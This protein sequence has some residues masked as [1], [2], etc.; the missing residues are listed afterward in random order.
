MIKI[1]KYR[2]KTNIILALAFAVLF[3][4]TAGCKPKDKIFTI[5][6]INDVSVLSPTFEGF[7]GGMAELDYIEGNNVRYIYNGVVENSQ[8][9]I[10]SEIK[11]LMAQD[12]D[13]FLTLGNNTSLLAKEALKETE[14]PILI[15]ACNKPIKYGLIESMSYAGGNIT[16]V[17]VADSGPKALEWLLMI[18]PGAKKIFL[19]YNPDSKISVISLEGLDKASS[20]LGIEIV[21][22]EVHSFEETIAAIENLPEEIDAIFRIPSPILDSRSSEIS[23][24]AIKKKI[25]LGARLEL[26]DAVLM[27]YAADLYEVGRQTAR[28]ADQIRQGIRPADIPVET[29]DV[30]LTINLNTAEKIGLSIPD[31]ILAQANK[32]IR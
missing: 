31:G 6:V 17:I 14:M 18:V 28:L 11:K 7:K 13:M 1:F 3:I 20:Q 22:H 32:I 5:G 16:G 15:S 23:Q 8:K 10:D 19:P 2:E 25:P 29:S 26:D 4:M 27:T 12:V 21:Y 9:I 30:F 24:A